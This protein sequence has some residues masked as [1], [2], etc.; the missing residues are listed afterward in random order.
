MSVKWVC[1]MVHNPYMDQRWE[2]EE[3]GEEKKKKTP[4]M[5]RRV[6]VRQVVVGVFQRFHNDMMWEMDIQ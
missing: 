4:M 2:K 5:V 6:S 1:K 3:R